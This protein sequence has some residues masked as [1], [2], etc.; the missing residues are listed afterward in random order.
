MLDGIEMDVLCRWLDEFVVMPAMAIIEVPE[1]VYSTLVSNGL[2]A[3]NGEVTE[4]G[5]EYV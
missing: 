4:R 2:L 1:D 3:P 5:H